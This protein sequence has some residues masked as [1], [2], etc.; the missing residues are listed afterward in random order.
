VTAGASAAG[1]V[2]AAKWEAVRDSP[3]RK[4][5]INFNGLA[6]ARIKTWPRCTGDEKS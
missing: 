6:C 4:G 1:T 3:E 5:S 2:T